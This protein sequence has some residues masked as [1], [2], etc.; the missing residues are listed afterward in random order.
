MGEEALHYVFI[1]TK[2]MFVFIYLETIVMPKLEC[3]LNH[4]VTLVFFMPV[5]NYKPCHLPL[6]LV[7][8]I[9]K[10]DHTRPTCL[11]SYISKNVTIMWLII[12]LYHTPTTY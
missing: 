11:A 6:I 12:E 3:I 7:C 1:L 2:P 5:L 8:K 4:V 10:S 9:L